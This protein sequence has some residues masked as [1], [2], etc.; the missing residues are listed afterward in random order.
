MLRDTFFMA[1]NYHADIPITG[2]WY[3]FES[4]T[5][6][7][8]YNGATSKTSYTGLSLG[9]GK[10]KSVYNTEY[11]VFSKSQNSI[12]CIDIN[13]NERQLYYTD[14]NMGFVCLNN[15]HI[16]ITELSSSNI[17]T[18]SA[19][20]IVGA[21]IEPQLLLVSTKTFTGVPTPSYSSTNYIK[22]LK[23]SDTT[24][25]VYQSSSPVGFVQVTKSDDNDDNLTL[26]VVEGTIQD[27]GFPVADS[28]N[29]PTNYF[30]YFYSPTL[31]YYMIQAGSLFTIK[32]LSG[33]VIASI[34]GTN[35]RVFIDNN[36]NGYI[37]QTGVKT[38]SGSSRLWSGI[39]SLIDGTIT[40]IQEVDAGANSGNSYNFSINNGLFPLIE[41]K[42]P[43]ILA[44]RSTLIYGFSYTISGVVF[45]NYSGTSKTIDTFGCR[46]LWL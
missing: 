39:Y 25:I 43:P 11:I 17:L 8:I 3:A 41:N 16:I 42:I 34:A 22:C 32:N 46:V 29:N 14:N 15:K 37:T 9:F 26:E 1:Q 40:L 30:R 13:D 45:N 19:Y 27:I 7:N 33:D 10:V 31:N 24:A 35:I 36:G 44:V 38:I 2:T 28:V 21:A 12:N 18:V 6:R 4:D 23:K 20:L 5:A